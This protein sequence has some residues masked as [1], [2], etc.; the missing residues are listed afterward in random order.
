LAAP[1]IDIN[2]LEQ[3]LLRQGHW[4]HRQTTFLGPVPSDTSNV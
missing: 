4:F 3:T 2:L 1:E